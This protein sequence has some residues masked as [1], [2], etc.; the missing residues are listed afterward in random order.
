M[1]AITTFQETDNIDIHDA[2]N[3]IKKRIH[4][5]KVSFNGTPIRFITPQSMRHVGER[6]EC[7]QSYLK[8]AFDAYHAANGEPTAG[9]PKKDLEQLARKIASSCWMMFT[10][11]TQHN[12]AFLLKYL[13]EQHNAQDENLP[14]LEKL[15]RDDVY[16]GFI[17][18]GTFDAF[19]EDKEMVYTPV[20]V[21]KDFRFKHTHF[22]SSL[23]FMHLETQDEPPVQAPVER[24]YKVRIHPACIQGVELTATN[25]W[26]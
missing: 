5:G 16:E 3:E 6:W 18:D 7:V 2:E 10:I 4:T 13:V 25:S 26:L 15:I 14:N 9:V 22:K 8:R 19:I 17:E 1:S 20:F 11:A 23:P 12:G 24:V 21:F